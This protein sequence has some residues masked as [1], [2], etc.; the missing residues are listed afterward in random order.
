M[1]LASGIGLAMG[2]ALPAFLVGL[3]ENIMLHKSWIKAMTAH[4]LSLSNS[5]D[6]IYAWVAKILPLGPSV[7]QGIGFV[8]G[9]LFILAGLL[10]ILILFHLSRE[11]QTEGQ[12]SRESIAL[13][14]F[15]IEYFVI[16]ALIP[17]LVVTDTEHFLLSLPV[18]ILIWDYL[19]YFRKGERLLV[20][21]VVVACLLY[22]GNWHDAVGDRL[23]K[24]MGQNGILGLGN[25][26]LIFIGVWIWERGKK[27]PQVH[28]QQ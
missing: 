6:T 2:V 24:W 26:L 14:D 1:L 25:L 23:S 9:T 5:P 17:N 28:I 7:E 4:N 18:L 16:L 22:G 13:A 11:R 3:K 20:S 15:G 8:T 10:L 19:L 27:S 21:L 12:S